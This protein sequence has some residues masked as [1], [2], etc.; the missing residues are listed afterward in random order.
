MPRIFNLNEVNSSSQMISLVIK[1]QLRGL[2]RWHP[3]INW[4]PFTTDPRGY[5][6]ETPVEVKN[7]VT[8]MKYLVVR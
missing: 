5:Q 4:N 8:K 1:A 6:I 7:Q 2:Y 3:V